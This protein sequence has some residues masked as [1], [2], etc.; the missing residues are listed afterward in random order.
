MAEASTHFFVV[1]WMLKE[2]GGNLPIENGRSHIVAPCNTTLELQA[3]LGC[4]KIILTLPDCCH[5]I[6]KFFLLSSCDWLILPYALSSCYRS[7]ETWY[8]NGTLCSLLHLQT[9]H[10]PDKWLAV[11]ELWGASRCLRLIIH[12]CFQ[13]IPALATRPCHQCRTTRMLF[14]VYN[15]TTTFLRKVFIPH[16]KM[17]SNRW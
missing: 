17:T 11:L 2:P 14:L 13:S 4:N 15:L 9:R 1:K 7:G 6:Y 5:H 12:N 16:S 10:S 8:Q 3:L